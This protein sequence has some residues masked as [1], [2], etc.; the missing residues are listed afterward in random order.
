MGC[1][2]SQS[3]VGSSVGTSKHLK[4]NL[5][6]TNQYPVLGWCFTR[7]GCKVW[8]RKY[9]ITLLGSKKTVLCFKGNPGNWSDHSFTGNNV[10]FF[11]PKLYTSF[12]DTVFNNSC[13]YRT[14]FSV[15]IHANTSIVGIPSVFWCWIKSCF[16]PFPWFCFLMA[17]IGHTI[18][19]RHNILI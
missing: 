8:N 9:C 12:Q 3:P 16:Y 6:F 15:I 13:R 5:V 17:K 10:K 14:I 7:W 19:V 1:K 11:S 4:V 18:T 2:I